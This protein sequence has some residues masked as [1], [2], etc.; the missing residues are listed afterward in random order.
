MIPRLDME[1]KI[2]RE[3]RKHYGKRNTDED[4]V[5]IFHTASSLRD[6]AITSALSISPRRASIMNPA[7]TSGSGIL[8]IRP[9]GSFTY[10]AIALS[11]LFS[12]LVVI[13]ALLAC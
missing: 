5:E 9:C 4:D 8:R 1:G 13:P 10:S 11:I 12:M 6:S 2:K 7:R 3:Y